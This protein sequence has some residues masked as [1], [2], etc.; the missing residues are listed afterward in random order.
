MRYVICILGISGLIWFL[1]PLITSGICNIGNIS[2]MAGSL[3]ILLYGIFMRQIHI[4][5]KNN[6]LYLPGK[7][8]LTSLGVVLISGLIV[9]VILADL[10][11]SA[12]SRQPEGET[13]VVVLGCG[14]YGERPSLILIERMDAACEFLMQHPDTICIL[15]GGQGEGEDISEAEC[16]YRYLTKKGIEP[17]RLYKEEASVSTRENILYS[18]RIIEEN[19]LATDMTIVTNEFHQYRAGKIAE[20]LGITT[21]AVSGRTAWWLFPTFSVRE[22]FG[23]VYE[24][25]F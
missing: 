20:K 5:I 3:S 18:K 21:Y 11:I 17:E 22:M 6:W 12:S 24:A 14:V 1:L 23:I 10:M 19:D 8:G 25:V 2:G 16:M 7:I 9:I 4:F 13:T 15:S